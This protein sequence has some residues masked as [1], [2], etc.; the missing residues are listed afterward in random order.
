MGVSTVLIV[1]LSGC[2]AP[3][4][5]PPD[6][7]IGE[8]VAAT[9][10][11]VPAGTAY[12]WYDLSEAVLHQ[13][14]SLIGGPAP[15]GE[16]GVVIAVCADADTIAESTRITTGAIPRAAYDD[17]VRRRAAAGDYRH[18]LPECADR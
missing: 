12:A 5:V 8:P 2:S 11:H 4:S 6:T 9:V 14:G 18:L 7:L 10:R 16:G 1:A 15:D 17:T 3:P 13:P